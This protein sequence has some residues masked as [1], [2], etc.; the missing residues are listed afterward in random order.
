M[1]NKDN[2]KNKSSSL[3]KQKKRT[4]LFVL[5][6]G[7]VLVIGI[8]IL[9]LLIGSSSVSTQRNKPE[10]SFTGHPNTS[11]SFFSQAGSQTGSYSSNSG[12]TTPSPLSKSNV[13]IP[14]GPLSQFNNSIYPYLQTSQPVS[15]T[16]SPQN[17]NRKTAHIIIPG[18]GNQGGSGQSSSSNQQTQ[19]F[20]SSSRG[21]G[22]P[23]PT[24]RPVNITSVPQGH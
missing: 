24:M 5:L 21:S 6:V 13:H 8:L 10:N 23:S 12:Q 15:I 4:R 19:S 14:S 3:Q 17:Q 20:F 18:Q 11:H 22:L 9:K 7:L 2:L 16:P 1:K